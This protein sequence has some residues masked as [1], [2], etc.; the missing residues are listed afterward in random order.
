MSYGNWT[1]K[2]FRNKVRVESREDVGVFDEEEANLSSRL[3]IWANIIKINENGDNNKWWKHSHHA[4]L[5]DAEVRLCAYKDT[6]ELWILGK[7]PKKVK[8]IKEGDWIGD[9]LEKSGEI[10]IKKRV[11]KWWFKCQAE[12]DM[13]NLKLEEPDGTI[14]TAKSGLKEEMDD[15]D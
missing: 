4:V 7:K 5:G 6:P 10:T 1:S 15:E 13:I 11:W 2:V 9:T 3:R 12:P 8:L 14:W